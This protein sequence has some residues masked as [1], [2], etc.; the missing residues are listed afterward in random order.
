MIRNRPQSRKMGS[1]F[2]CVIGEIAKTRIPQIAKVA[3][4]CESQIL[5]FAKIGN[6]DFPI[7]SWMNQLEFGQNDHREDA[8]HFSFGSRRILS[9]SFLP[10]YEIQIWKILEI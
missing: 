3:K 4:S 1:K 2:D 7:F 9:G 6:L 10:K 5:F 8:S